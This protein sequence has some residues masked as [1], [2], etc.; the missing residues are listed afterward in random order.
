MRHM[1]SMS[2]EKSGENG[3]D[4]SKSRG[5]H[6]LALQ[7]SESGIITTTGTVWNCEI[8][9]HLFEDFSLNSGCQQV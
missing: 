7:D 3:L 8:C 1:P 4:R 6:D 5:P 9:G 2:V